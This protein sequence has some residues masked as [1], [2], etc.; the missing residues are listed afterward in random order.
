MPSLRIW[1]L[2]CVFPLL[3]LHGSVRADMILTNLTSNDLAAYNP[4][5]SSLAYSVGLR[6]GSDSVQLDE[7]IL[8]LKATNS[9]GV[10]TVELR[11]TNGNA[12]AATPLMTFTSQTVDSTD[13][14]NYTFTP[15]SSVTLQANTLYWFTILNSFASGNG[16]VISASNPALTPSGVNASYEGLRFGTP[17]NQAVNVV[18]LSPPN[19]QI[20]GSIT[21]VPEPTTWL[22]ILALTSVGLSRFRRKC[23]HVP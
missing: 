12:P 6:V 15:G 22:G 18:T 7:V 3:L 4:V 8:R 13:F 14:G 19:F 2:A 21:A 16:L 1:A 11:A 9:P 23:R 5:S 17:S 20:G 10:A